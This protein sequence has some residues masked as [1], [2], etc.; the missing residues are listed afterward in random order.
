[1]LTS[2][3]DYGGLRPIRTLSW[4]CEILDSF[5]IPQDLTVEM[6]QRMYLYPHDHR[7]LL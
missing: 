7:C 4:I 6:V 3:G 5:S 2:V 1:M